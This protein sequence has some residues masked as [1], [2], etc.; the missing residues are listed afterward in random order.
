[1]IGN[2]N[3]DLLQLTAPVKLHARTVRQKSLCVSKTEE[4]YPCKN[5]QHVLRVKF[6]QY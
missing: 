5:M 2:S 3:A 1:V 4:Q 6:L